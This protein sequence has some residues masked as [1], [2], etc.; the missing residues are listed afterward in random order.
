MLLLHT[1][2]AKASDDFAR[3]AAAALLA[4]DTGDIRCSRREPALDRNTPFN[5]SRVES[6]PLPFGA[7]KELFDRCLWFSLWIDIATIYNLC[8]TRQ[9]VLKRA[10]DW[11][12]S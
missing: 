2:E 11:V 4:E 3:S 5:M 7:Q 1:P 10:D 8:A 12:T 6:M 9:G